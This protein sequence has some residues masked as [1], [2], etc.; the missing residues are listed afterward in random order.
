MS[1]KFNYSE[2]HK[3]II[4]KK[5]ILMMLAMFACITMSAQQWVTGNLKLDSDKSFK[6]GL[7]TPNQRDYLSC[8][9]QEARVTLEVMD[10][11]SKGQTF[12]LYEHL[13][14]ADN[15]KLHMSWSGSRYRMMKQVSGDTEVYLLADGRTGKQLLAYM[16]VKTDG[17]L[18]TMVNL[19]SN[20]GLLSDIYKGMTVTELNSAISS[21]GS[22]NAELK[23]SHKEGNLTVHACKIANLRENLN[24]TVSATKK[25]YGHFYFDA[26]GKLVKWIIYND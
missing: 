17:K 22:M 18:V 21:L 20:D 26:Q 1:M 10:F 14:A 13:I 23:E 12:Y 24:G 2:P 7:K 11:G 25:D 5:N 4:M 6:V 15:M 8:T 16:N 19:L 9:P 3:E